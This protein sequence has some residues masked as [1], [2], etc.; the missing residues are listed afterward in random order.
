MEALL[1]NTGAEE[2]SSRILTHS[3]RYPCRAESREHSLERV[4]EARGPRAR[5]SQCC[6][7]RRQKLK[8]LR[9]YAEVLSDAVLVSQ[10]LIWLTHP[11][12]FRILHSFS[13]DITTS[14]SINNQKFADPKMHPRTSPAVWADLSNRE[15]RTA[16]CV[17][18]S[19]SGCC[20]GVTVPA[21]MEVQA[22]P[23]RGRK[24]R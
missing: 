23:R 21:V 9:E 24:R 8:D 20:T 17:A 11:I 5:T 19:Q 2:Q 3:A 4:S 15:A 18:R 10:F 6:I 16:P 12:L 7:H 22:G 13:H 14:L 1:T